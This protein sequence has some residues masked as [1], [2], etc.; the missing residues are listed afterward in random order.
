MVLTFFSSGKMEQRVT[1]ARTYLRPPVRTDWADWAELRA[2]SRDYLQ[3][4]EPSWA[5]DV[6]S[7]P[8][9]RYR[10]IRYADDWE[11]GRSYSFFIFKRQDDALL[12]AITLSNVRRGVTQT[13]SFGYWIGRPYANQGFMTEAVGGACC[14]AFDKL[15]LNRVEAAC[16]PTNYASQSVLKKAGFQR[17][18]FARKYLRINGQWE[19]HLLF[20]MLRDDYNPDDRPELQA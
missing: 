7:K 8:S 2:E 1:Q 16:L 17:E 11:N 9:F 13:C 20:A 5:S 18:G 15:A 12:G 6:L 14:F 4:W 10:L 19:D 3:P